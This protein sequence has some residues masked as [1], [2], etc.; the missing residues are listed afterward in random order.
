MNYVYFKND[1]RPSLALTLKRD[2]KS[3]DL[4]AATS[5]NLRLVNRETGVLKFS[6]ACALTT[7]ASG[8]VT[9]TWGAT[10]L[11]TVGTYHV[12][13]EINWA[14]GK[15]ET[16]RLPEGLQVKDKAVSV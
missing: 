3:E 4:S 15:T 14:D 11:D 1:R 16:R 6:G 13:I 2:G 7:P 12:E 10:D 9:Y 5:V 8:L